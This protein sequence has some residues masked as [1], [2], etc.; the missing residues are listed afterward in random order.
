VYCQAEVP[1]TSHIFV[2]VGLGFHAE[3]TLV[4]AARA[5]HPHPPAARSLS[6]HTRVPVPRTL[7]AC[8]WH[9]SFLFEPRG[10]SLSS[11][12]LLIVVKC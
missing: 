7:D 4:R 12:N 9:I 8:T 3:L 11:F 6:P 2:N 1:D 10:T 5:R